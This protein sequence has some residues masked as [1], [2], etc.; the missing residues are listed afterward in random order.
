LRL[1]ADGSDYVSLIHIADMA[2]ATARALERWQARRALLVADDAPSRW[3]DVLRFVAEIAGGPE[4]RDGGRR[5][6]PSF[7]MSNR[8]LVKLWGGCRSIR[9]SVLASYASDRDERTWQMQ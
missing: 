8:R 1:P 4:P 6:F 3:S 2:E 9:T 5:G 7:R